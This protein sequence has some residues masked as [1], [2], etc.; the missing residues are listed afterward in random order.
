MSMILYYIHCPSV[1][2]SGAKVTQEIEEAFR[3][4]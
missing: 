3:Q 1:Y 2:A 4:G